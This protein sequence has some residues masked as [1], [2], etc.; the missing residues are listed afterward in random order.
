M[1]EM[2]NFLIFFENIFVNRRKGELFLEMKFEEKNENEINKNSIFIYFEN[3][4]K[5]KEIY[6]RNVSETNKEKIK[7]AVKHFFEEKIKNEFKKIKEILEK[8]KYKEI[9]FYK[10]RLEAIFYG[11]GY[12]LCAFEK[13]K[14]ENGFL[15]VK[16]IFLKENDD[17]LIDLDYLKL[18]QGVEEIIF[19]MKMD[20]E[21]TEN[22]KSMEKMMN[23]SY[24]HRL[25]LASDHSYL[26]KIKQ[27]DKYK[28]LME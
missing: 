9:D 21:K 23:S 10:K 16:T 27:F 26:E 1:I 15:E 22:E 19:E 28:G 3:D 2:D 25:Y 12:E 8:K 13:I 17:I 7:E 5:I 4:L 24:K 11:W 18:K 20:S 14:I 6:V